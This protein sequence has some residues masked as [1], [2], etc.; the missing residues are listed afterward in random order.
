MTSTVDANLKSLASMIEDQQ[1]GVPDMFALIKRQL[2]RLQ[3]QHTDCTAQRTTLLQLERTWNDAQRAELLGSEDRSVQATTD[4]LDRLKDARAI[5]LEC[6][7]VGA[8]TLTDLKRQR[9]VLTSVQSNL[10]NTE[11]E[12]TVSNTFLNRMMRWWRK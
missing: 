5:L 10:K 12:L 7:E 1:P 6:E 2:T 3:Q 4:S 8:N 9:D 11:S